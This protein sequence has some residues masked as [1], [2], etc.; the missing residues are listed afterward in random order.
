MIRQ[1][2]GTSRRGCGCLWLLLLLLALCVVAWFARA[3]ILTAAGAFLVEDDGPHPADVAVVMGGDEYGDRVL[4]AAKLASKGYAPYV[5][6]SFEPRFTPY[7]DETK[8]YAESKGYPDTL[9]REFPNNAESTRSE[10]QDLEGYFQ[11]H[12]IHTILLVTSNYHTRRAAQM[13]RKQ[14]PRLGIWVEPAPDPYFQP[15]TWWKT[16]EGQKTFFHEW[17]KTIATRLG[18]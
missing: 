18:Y 16:R 10:V 11:A 3:P 5:L 15:S 12:G 13:M 9:F 17:L 6:I 1:P 2:G 8:L 4:E 7:C 14:D